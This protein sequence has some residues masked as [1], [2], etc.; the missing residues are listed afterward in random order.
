MK[1]LA[2]K[3]WG[4][5]HLQRIKWCRDVCLEY[6]HYGGWERCLSKDSRRIL[7]NLDK[8]ENCQCKNHAELWQRLLYRYVSSSTVKS[9]GFIRCENIKF[10]NWQELL[11]VLVKVRPISSI[12]VIKFWILWKCL[13]LAIVWVDQHSDVIQS[14]V[15]VMY[16]LYC[17]VPWLM[18]QT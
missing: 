18:S 15:G 16:I 1:K 6:F 11:F 7:L 17:R 14:G 12:S 10:P 5:N 8:H 4:E 2:M 13:S 3:C 9:Q